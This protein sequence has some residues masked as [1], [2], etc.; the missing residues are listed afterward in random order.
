AG[1]DVVATDLSAEH[2]ARCWEK[3]LDART[4]D[5]LGLIDEFGSDAFDACYAMNCL[6]HV[7]NAVLPGVLDG[8]AHVL[9]PGGL[10]LVAAYAGDD[11]EGFPDWDR[12]RPPRFFS[13]R[14]PATMRRLLEESLDIVDARVLDEEEYPVQVVTAV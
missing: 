7:P 8:I 2:V 3:G 13:L 9:R 14:T 1:L 10:L 11:Y 6:L 5:F 4:V 12:H